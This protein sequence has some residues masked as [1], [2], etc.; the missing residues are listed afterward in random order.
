MCV[1]CVCTSRSGCRIHLRA[2]EAVSAEEEEFCPYPKRPKVNKQERQRIGLKER[3][4]C[5]AR[6]SGAGARPRPRLGGLQGRAGARGPGARGPRGEVNR[7]YCLSFSQTVLLLYLNVC[8]LCVPA[9]WRLRAATPPFSDF[10]RT[11]RRWLRSAPS[12]AFVAYQANEQLRALR[13]ETSTALAAK[14][15]ELASSVLLG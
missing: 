7:P 6:G 14:D 2:E 15:G 1:L 5:R 10:C 4:R 11:E 12:R 13:E 9:R 3:G 8:V